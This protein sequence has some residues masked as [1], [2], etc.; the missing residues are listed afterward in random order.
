MSDLTE[1]HDLVAAGTRVPLYALMKK[2]VFQEY[3]APMAVAE[4]AVEAARSY[5]FYTLFFGTRP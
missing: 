1:Y 3:D 5:S 4:S 2:W